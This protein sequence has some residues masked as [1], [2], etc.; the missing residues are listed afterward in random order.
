MAYLKSPSQQW[1]GDT[2]EYH[3]TPIM[4]DDNQ[5]EFQTCYRKNI[6]SEG[7]RCKASFANFWW[8][9]SFTKDV[10]KWKNHSRYY[11]KTGAGLSLI[12]GV[13]NDCVWQSIQVYSLNS[14]K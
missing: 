5:A 7:H 3:K 1:P 10:G 14:Q 11:C 9:A 8:I 4:I 12:R 2:E 6:S 13:Q